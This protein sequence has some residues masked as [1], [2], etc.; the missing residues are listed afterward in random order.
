M[1]TKYQKA[2]NFIIAGDT[3]DLKLNMILQ[4]SPKIK[5]VV[6]EVTRLNPPRILDPIMTTLS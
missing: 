3:N 5:Q 6:T 1:S 4:I 2:L